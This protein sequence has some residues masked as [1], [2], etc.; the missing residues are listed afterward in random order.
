MK[1]P[2]GRERWAASEGLCPAVATD[3]ILEAARE[4]AKGSE[5][6]PLRLWSWLILGFQTDESLS[7]GCGCGIPGLRA[8]ETMQ[9]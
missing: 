3:I 7:G 1:G 6:C 9:H 5:Q 2:G 8:R 4:H